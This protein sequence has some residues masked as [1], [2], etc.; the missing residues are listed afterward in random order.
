MSGNEII[1]DTNI[2]LYLLKGS[3]TLA[4]FLQ[5]KNLHISFIT[6]LELIGFRDI[7]S[8]EERAIESLLAECFIVPLNTSIKKEYIQLRRKYSL[9]LAD[10]IIAATAMAID[11]PLFTADKQFGKIKDLSL[12]QFTG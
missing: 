9:K 2:I 5:G 1:V 11:L 7:S 3:D 6:E 4:N 12:I 10:A 8:R